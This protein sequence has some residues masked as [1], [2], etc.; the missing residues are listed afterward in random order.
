MNGQGRQQFPA[1]VFPPPPRE[2]DLPEQRRNMTTDLPNYAYRTMYDNQYPGGQPPPPPKAGSHSNS[3]NRSH[4]SA[5]GAPRGRHEDE[6]FGRPLE[7][8]H[9]QSERRTRTRDRRPRRR[10]TSSYDSDRSYDSR[11]SRHYRDDR[12][13]RGEMRSRSRRRSHERDK[14]DQEVQKNQQQNKQQQQ[15]QEEE[16]KTGFAK[17]E[18][19][20]TP[21][22][23]GIL[24]GCMDLI[25]GSIS[26]YMTNKRFSKKALAKGPAPG[27][28]GSSSGGKDSGDKTGGADEKQANDGAN[29]GRGSRGKRGAR[30][31]GSARNR[32]R[33]GDLYRERDPYSRR[34]SSAS[35]STGTSYWSLS[36]TRRYRHM[37][38]RLEY[39][40]RGRPKSAGARALMRGHAGR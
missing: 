11:E 32:E 15:G 35:D 18:E 29:K 19:Y 5:H 22:N 7:D 40:D 27:E 3:S 12:R 17:I 39:D 20:I 13:R 10:P 21:F 26:L 2:E 37:P 31:T 28:P 6:R 14:R 38:E 36:D 24:M 8:G 25:G 30:S 9:Y 16:K 1:P 34:D 23:V 4:R 33:E